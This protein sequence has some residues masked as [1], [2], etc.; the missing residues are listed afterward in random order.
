MREDFSPLHPRHH[1]SSALSVDAAVPLALAFTAI[2]APTD[3][4]YHEGIRHHR[5]RWTSL[6]R[7]LFGAGGKCMNSDVYN[8]N[9]LFR[10]QHSSGAGLAILFRC[11]MFQEPWNYTL[12]IR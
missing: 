6:R 2:D 4:D 3:R 11:T 5:L 9:N 7:R 1:S 8:E 10:V 12:D